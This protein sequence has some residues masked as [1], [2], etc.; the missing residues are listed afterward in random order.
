M[1]TS[2]IPSVACQY[3]CSEQVGYR[4]VS[5][6]DLLATLT[7]LCEPLGCYIV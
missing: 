4:C 6:G 7:A 1:K 3:C 5:I 2:P